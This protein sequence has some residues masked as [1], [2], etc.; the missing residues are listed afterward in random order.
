MAESNEDKTR[1]IV[2]EFF[3]RQKTT[4]NKIIGI[5]KIGTCRLTVQCPTGATTG[6]FAHLRA[7]HPKAHK[8]CEARNEE[9]R[10]R[11]FAEQE[12][13]N[14]NK[15]QS[16]VDDLFNKKALWSSSHP[17]AIAITNSVGRMLAL[18]MLPYE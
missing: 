15:K 18:D 3:S 13:K 2:W 12:L 8:E 5:C 7:V 17:N 10:K 6:L 1:S 14:G 16:K 9:N 4:D 11:K